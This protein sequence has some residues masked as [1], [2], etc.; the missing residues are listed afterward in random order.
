MNQIDAFG[1]ISL[2]FS[3]NLVWNSL[4]KRIRIVSPSSILRVF[5]GQYGIHPNKQFFFSQKKSQRTKTQDSFRLAQYLFQI[6]LAWIT[7]CSSSQITI[8]TK[9]KVL[10]KE[11]KTRNSLVTHTSWGGGGDTKKTVET[12]SR[13]PHDQRRKVNK[14]EMCPRKHIF[15][16][17]IQNWKRRF[18]KSTII[19]SN[20]IL[21]QLGAKGLVVGNLMLGPL[22]TNPTVSWKINFCFPFFFFKKKLFLNHWSIEIAARKWWSTRMGQTVKISMHGLEHGSPF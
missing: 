19:D 4:N 9:K 7:E 20:S 18:S 1:L 21:I 2:Y 11:K 8:T 6:A 14:V 13:Q 22:A 15:L 10:P 3:I 16:S 5:T 12:W 17:K